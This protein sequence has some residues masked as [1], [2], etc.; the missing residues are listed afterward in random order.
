MT[1]F[2]PTTS[3][4][5]KRIRVRVVVLNYNG[6]ELVLRCLESLEHLDWPREALEVVLVDNGSRDGSVAAVRR[7]FPSVCVIEA[8]RNL[9]F[10]AGNNLGLVDL[11]DAD[12]VALLNNDATVDSGWLVPLVE[13]LEA[14]A[15]LGATCP[16]ILFAPS[17]VDVE[18]EAPSFRP[19]RGDPRELS[20]RASG[21]EIDGED[22]WPDTQFGPGWYAPEPGPGVEAAFRWTGPRATLRVPAGATARIRLAAEREKEVTVR[23]GRFEERVAV[24]PEPAWVE[25]RLDGRPYDVVNNAGSV[26][27]AGGY[28]GDRGFLEVDSGQYD[29]PAEVFAWCGCSVLLRRRYLEEVGLFDERLFLYY[30]DFDLSWRGRAQG[31]RYLY[32]PRSVV[33]HVHTAT[34]V[35]G[36]PLF[37]HYVERNRLLVHV[38][39]APAGYA[40]RA[41]ADWLLPTIWF[42]ARDMVSPLLHGRRPS[43]ALVGRRLRAFAAFL[44]LLPAA[45]AERRRLRR[46][47][48]VPD[49]ELLAWA[50]R[51]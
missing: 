38:K 26:L 34:S 3:E 27:V 21:V 39:N 20:V 41:V 12:Y 19:G 22:R 30:E 17:F 28:G 43:G 44:R 9:G 36:S 15:G 50:V 5:Q 51:R 47:Q 31:W 14:D 42:T 46:H 40:A 16:K 4:W 29:E 32:V 25:V 45:L 10:A 35:E 11:G 37:A 33:R 13:A 1:A 6:G 18:L 24:G 23:S 49:R 8:G 7:R 2:E 48:R